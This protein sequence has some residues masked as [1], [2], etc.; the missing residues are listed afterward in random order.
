LQQDVHSLDACVVVIQASN[1][2]E[3]IV[4]ARQVAIMMYYNGLRGQRF[5]PRCELPFA[6]GMARPKIE[7]LGYVLR[8]IF[9]RSHASVDSLS[10]N[11]F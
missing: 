8:G 4:P 9:Q 5:P 2:L 11:P 7:R 10:R 3:T 6:R 1:C